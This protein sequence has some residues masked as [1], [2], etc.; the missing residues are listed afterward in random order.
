MSEI[1]DFGRKV[2]YIMKQRGITQSWLAQKI[3]IT[4]ATLSRY[5]NNS[6]KPQ[7]DIAADIAEVLDI[8]LDYLMGISGCPSPIKTMSTEETLLISA[9]SKA[10]PRDRKI[11]FGVL[12]D[13]MTSEELETFKKIQKN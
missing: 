6:R 3:G 10:S 7:A 1:M 11:I 2:K 5:V 12:E 9:F 4:E 8:S 13:H